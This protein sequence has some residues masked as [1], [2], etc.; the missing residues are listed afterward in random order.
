MITQIDL[1]DFK[2]FSNATVRFGD[3]TMLIGANASGKS[4]LRDAL[5]FLHGVGLANSLAE[6][7]GPK[8]GEGGILQWRG[9]RGGVRE[10]TR[11]AAHRFGVGASVRSVHGELHYWITVEIGDKALGPQV[12]E[13]HLYANGEMVFDS[14]PDDDP[15]TDQGPSH[16]L[17]V[18]LP[19]GGRHR[20]HG[21]VLSVTASRPAVTQIARH[22]RAPGP[23]A[24]VCK[25]LQSFL[26]SIRFLDLDPEAMRQASQPGQTILGDR[27]ENLSSVLQGLCQDES[28]KAALMQWIQALTP[29]DAADLKFPQDHSGQVLVH[30]VE[31]EDR[32]IS[33]NSAS[34]GTLR[35]L[36]L[37]AALLSNDSGQVYVFEELDNGIHPARLSLLLQLLE[38]ACSKPK[39]QVIATTHQVIATTHH[40]SL[41]AFLSPEA[42]DA[43]LVVT[44]R[45]SDGASAITRVM[46]LPS[47]RE[48]MESE[49][50]GQL[51]E[52]G[53]FE[54]VAAFIEDVDEAGDDSVELT[55]GKEE[56]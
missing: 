11:F 55:N 6:I 32:L 41:L 26:S 38:Q 1:R 25:S 34:D 35:F 28:M 39:H 54:T 43:A 18:R 37:I 16:E 2:S 22:D 40:P 36:A 44:R 51:H 19:R 7:I 20:K 12:V 8:Y 9:I 48:V 42:R 24:A 5:R 15:I 4:N 47:I 14:S 21:Q 31:G 49:S 30:L 23:Q 3:L 50:L 53:W 29:L 13:E 17:R 10:I 27:G 52:A 45:E 46:D 33:A 56:S